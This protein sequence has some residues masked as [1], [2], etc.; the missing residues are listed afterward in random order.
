MATRRTIP[1]IHPKPPRLPTH[2]PHPRPPHLPTLRT[3]RPTGTTL[4][5][6]HIL[7]HAQGGTNHPDNGQTLCLPCHKTKT[8]QEA[9][10][11]RAHHNRRPREPHPASPADQAP[12]QHQEGH[13]PSPPHP[14]PT[15]GLGA[16]CAYGSGDF[17]AGTL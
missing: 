11:A 4:Q 13:H 2:R 16:R 5:A 17:P 6:D 12:R 3:P 8:G 15:E 10:A 7:N 9:A 14:H 1:H